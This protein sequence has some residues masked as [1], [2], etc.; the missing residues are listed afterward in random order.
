MWIVTLKTESTDFLAPD[1]H[2]HTH[3]H[4]HTQIMQDTDTG[5]LELAVICSTENYA[6]CMGFCINAE[7]GMV[8]WKYDVKHKQ[9]LSYHNKILCVPQAAL[10][11]FGHC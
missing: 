4:T 8:L 10:A 11:T 9:C 6:L 7:L 3:T 2:T 5:V 1:A